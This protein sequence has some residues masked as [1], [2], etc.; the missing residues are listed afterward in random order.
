MDE[1]I[2]LKQLELMKKNSGE[3]RLAAEEWRSCSKTHEFKTHFPDGGISQIIINH[4]VKEYRK[5]FGC[6]TSTLKSIIDASK[7]MKPGINS[8][9]LPDHM[10]NLTI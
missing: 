8:M 2:A 3:M 9:T 5:N 6:A 7:S 4:H 10:I 1:K